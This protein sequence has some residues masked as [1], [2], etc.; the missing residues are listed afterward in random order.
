MPSR[1]AWKRFWCPLGGHISLDDR[2]F[3][4]DP[5]GEYARYYQEHVEP[6]EKLDASPCL[7]LLGE[8]GLGKSVAV[9]TYRQQVQGAL[10]AAG[11]TVLAFDLNRFA[12]DAYL[13]QSVFQNPRLLAWREGGG[14]LHLFLDGLDECLIRIDTLA[15][16]LPAE[17]EPLPR[18]RLR[19]RLV[20]RTAV[21]P[22]P[23]EGELQ[24]LF[25]EDAVR[26]H[27]LTPLRR[28]DLAEAAAQCHLDAASFLEEID[29]RE[30]A[31]LAMKPVTLR[32][33][34]NLFG[35]EGG[36][37]RSQTDLYHQ[38]C[39]RLAEEDS[40][41][42][43]AAGR[44]GRFS[45]AQRL[46]VASRIAA[47]MLYCARPAVCTGRDDGSLPETFLPL[48]TLVG[49][50]ESVGG[51]AFEVSEA[52]VRETLDTGLF[53][54]RGP[55]SLGFAHQTYA[56]FL[57]A[58]YLHDHGMGLEQTLH[59]LTHQADEA[60]RIVPQLQETTAWLA[61]LQPA[62]FDY[63]VVRDPQALLGSDVAT[64]SAENRARLVAAL[65]TLFDEEQLLDDRHEHRQRYR[66]LGHPGLP[67]QLAPYIR[68]HGKNA[69]VRRVAIDIAEACEATALEGLLASVALDRT[70][71]HPTRVQAA[72]ALSRIGSEDATLRLRPC[73]TNEAGEDPDDELK[74][75]ALRTLWPQHVTPAELFAALTEPKKSNFT[76]AYRLFLTHELPGSLP[77]SALPDALRWV[78]H[79][80]PDQE[81]DSPF[82]DL[83]EHVLRLAWQH[84]DEPDVLDAYAPLV[85]ARQQASLSVPGLDRPAD[86]DPEHERRRRLLAETVVPRLLA[87]R[88][89]PDVL[90]FTH[91]P[92][93]LAR[94]IPWLLSWLMGLGPGELQTYLARVVY[95][96]YRT[97]DLENANL[98]LEARETCPALRDV[99][100]PLFDAVD[101]HSA[102]ADLLRAHHQR[103]A[104]VQQRPR[105]RPVTPPPPERVS[106]CLDRSEAG[107]LNA[108]WQLNLE[109]TLKPD[110]THYG[111]E[112]EADIRA[113]P[114]WAEADTPT[115]GR[116]LSAARSYLTRAMPDPVRWAWGAMPHRPDLAA[117]RAFVL[118]VQEDWPFTESL[119]AEIWQRWAS[120]IAAFP[121]QHQP[122][123]EE[124]Q[125]KFF[126]VAYGHAPDC[127]LSTLSVLI[128]AEDRE[129]SFL[130]VH[131]RAGRCADER[132]ARALLAKAEQPGMKLST[133]GALLEFLLARGNEAALTYA[134]SLV[135]TPPHPD[136]S[137]RAMALTAA[138]V[139]LTQAAGSAWAAVW[140]AVQSN[141]L[142]GK[143]LIRRV[144]ALHDQQ[145][146][147]SLTRQLTA[148]Q[149]GELYLWLVRKFPPAADPQYEDVHAVGSREA[150]A[151]FRDAVLGQLRARG[152]PEAVQTLE[153]LAGTLP[154]LRFL[155]WVA[156]DAGRWALQRTWTPPTPADFYRLVRD[157]D[158]RVVQSGRQLLDVVLESLRRLGQKLQGE[159]PAA[160][161]L[162]NK[163]PT[164]TY[165]PKDENDLSNYVAL[166]LRED[167]ARRGIVVNR[168]VEIRRGEGGAEGERTDLHV[169]AIARDPQTGAVDVVTVIIEV[170]G[171]WHEELKQAL[172]TQLR[173]RYL[174]DN[175]CT[176]GLY[177]VGWFNCDQWDEKDSRRRKSPKMTVTEAQA[178]FDEQAAEASLGTLTLRAHVLHCALR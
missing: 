90:V 27:E 62:L 137:P 150:V 58:T 40:A 101:I 173:D 71:H 76:G 67:S 133:R 129:R 123:A 136:L 151:H 61:S 60:G 63:V 138:R 94:D 120:A 31:A 84:L 81:V 156:I 158:T 102:A 24:R 23:L 170:K 126:D 119:P 79:L 9:E 111:S 18:E 41:S 174:K 175:A 110:S 45:P 107:D 131:R 140:P 35:R 86:H 16:L 167:I 144:A 28:R 114:G 98:I 148:S 161:Y 49:G 66:K 85:A 154:E 26:V 146:A 15:A 5:Q 142:F 73:I 50:M 56:E 43:Q 166:H 19:L 53:S 134:S 7:V 20:C 157:R 163:S 12:S 91:H 88:Q 152:T 29:Q 65:L 32:F 160:P 113:M 122:A 143:T 92:L 172:V 100:A 52:A 104:E 42:R 3:L 39:L 64:M 57:A 82:R 171:S 37:P 177:L 11:D 103:W 139:L 164:G 2:G 115:R 145:H 25:G 112:F 121:T 69:I 132:L 47:V 118:L 14:N 176:H 147:A 135:P 141:E 38:G 74:G 44:P 130:S 22:S 117:Y 99:F 33:L 168:E 8:P 80:P 68:D 77:A 83:V 124:L 10:E 159:I 149:V 89:E 6:L 87:D 165:R 21:W 96:A 4:V 51:Q 1:Y 36:L 116:I 72:Y 59:L 155:K 95:A 46:A 105:R 178:F 128:D 153:R 127:V 106:R 169:D 17:L 109:L 48:Q 34:L 30:L 162:W 97:G 78:A 108:W 125:Q 93:L 55:Q 13:V 75:V 54:A 70:D